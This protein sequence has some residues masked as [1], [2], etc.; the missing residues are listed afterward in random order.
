MPTGVFKNQESLSPDFPIERHWD[1]IPHRTNQINML[2]NFYGDILE[3]KGE[4]FLRRLQ[5]IGP[6]GSGK[7]CTLKFFGNEFEHEPQV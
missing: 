1:E 2:W 7:T 4:S 6:S 3:K 5:I